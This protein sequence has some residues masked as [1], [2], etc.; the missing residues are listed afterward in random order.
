MTLQDTLTIIFNL[1]SD[2]KKAP[3]IKVRLKPKQQREKEVSIVFNNIV[4]V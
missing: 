2:N 4:L 3:L 1:F